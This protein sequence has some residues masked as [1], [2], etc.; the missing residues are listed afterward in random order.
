MDTYYNS[1]VEV[2]K[3][4]FEKKKENDRKR[5]QERYN[6]IKT[7]IESIYK[8]ITESDYKQLI[9]EAA[10]MGLTKV[11]IKTYKEE[12]SEEFGLSFLW[13]G[14]P[15]N[16]Y[17]TGVGLKYFQN[18]NIIPLPHL[19]QQFFNPF[20]ITMYFNSKTEEYCFELMW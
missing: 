4:N 15:Y 14:P 8:E 9:N 17:N 20:R 19:L 5:V 11:V 1:V 7:T 6:S 16:K 10:N 2:T 3:S 13:K 12:P 18:I